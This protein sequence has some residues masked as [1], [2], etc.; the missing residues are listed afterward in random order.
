MDCVVF[1]NAFSACHMNIQQVL[2]NRKTGGHKNIK[3]D[4]PVLSQLIKPKSSFDTHE[5]PYSLML[6]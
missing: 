4:D 2:V 3:T 6:F 1:I 5:I